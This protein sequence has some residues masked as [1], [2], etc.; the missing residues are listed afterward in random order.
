MTTAGKQ[1]VF[2]VGNS[3][4]AKHGDRRTVDTATAEKLVANGL[5]RL[6]DSK[7]AETAS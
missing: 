4:G 6:P 1:V 7:A 2:M 3:R 5:A